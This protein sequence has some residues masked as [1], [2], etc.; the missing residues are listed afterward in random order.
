M[1]E[2]TDS[3]FSGGGHDGLIRQM[4]TDLNKLGIQL[5]LDNFGS[6]HHTLAEIRDLP[7]TEVLISREFIQRMSE[8][9]EDATIV[10]STVEMCHQLGFSTVATGVEDAAT[11]KALQQA[12][13]GSAQGYHISRPLPADDAL[14]WWQQR[15]GNA[16][17]ASIRPASGSGKAKRKA[18][19]QQP[20]SAPSQKPDQP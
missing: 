6:S 5:A 1:L 7:L 3:G 4:L 12:G 11:V 10:R 14:F 19:A 20:L 15:S 13:C 9:R 8:H 2:I 17:D 16:G 18:P